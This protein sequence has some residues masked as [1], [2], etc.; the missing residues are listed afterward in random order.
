MLVGTD[1]DYTTG[2]Q[3]A[4]AAARSAGAT[5]VFVAGRPAAVLDALP[6]GLI[7]GAVALGDDVLAFVQTVRAAL[8]GD[9]E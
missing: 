4:A 3:T 1:A 6:D 7:D 5:A 2:L 9:Q 8:G